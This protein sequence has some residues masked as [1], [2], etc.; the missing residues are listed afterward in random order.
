M[1]DI[2]IK[3][4]ENP[5]GGKVFRVSGMVNGTRKRQNVK[6]EGEALTLKQNWERENMNLAPLPAITTRLTEE[7]AREAELCFSR[8]VSSPFTMTA[9]V[10]F[11]LTNYKPAS[12]A[13]TVQNAVALFL[14][15]KRAANKR[16]RTLKNL[17]QRLATFQT[18]HSTEQVGT[19][20]SDVLR[21]LI[22]R[23]KSSPLNRRNDCAAFTNFFNWCVGQEYCVKSP[24]D[25]IESPEWDI[26][27]PVSMS[28][29]EARNFMA[30]AQLPQF[31]HLVPYVV[32]GLFCGIR[33]TETSL[34]S[35]DAINLK[36][37]M[38]TIGAHIAKKR[39]RRVV[40]VSDNAAR[41]LLPHALE[42]TP[43][44]G[45]NWRRDFDALK[46][47]AGYNEANPWTPDL[48]R[49]TAISYHFAFHK[50]EGETAQWAGN[51]PDVIHAHYKGLI[52]DAADAA[53]FWEIVPG[54]AQ[55]VNLPTRKAA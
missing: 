39:G 18:R 35:W 14:G 51:S 46:L 49:H 17:A 53:D 40:A 2:V 19:V 38:V 50:H 26:K 36:S 22:F 52:T 43:L 28:L 54:T 34:L 47:A 44:A 1:N 45:V 3:P 15:E 5:G 11:A 6:T 7:Q 24:M 31:K 23:E 16:G 13:V 20:Q 32:L 37:N 30:K 10:D 55:V 25:K 29:A 4:F 9:A 12:K 33:P 27:E 41:F 42:K 21:A 48:L 8:L